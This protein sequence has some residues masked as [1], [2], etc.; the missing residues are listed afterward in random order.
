MSVSVAQIRIAREINEA[1]A[2]LNDALLKQSQL[3]AS[4]IVARRD[5][6]SDQLMGQDLLMRLNKSQH[7]LIVSGGNLARVHGRLLE[8]GQEL[9][10]IEECP[11]DW[12]QTGFDGES[13]AA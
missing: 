5:T 9:G 4:M 8:I 3:F 1:E 12:T 10:S 11:E 7:E 2:A 13:V 6:Q